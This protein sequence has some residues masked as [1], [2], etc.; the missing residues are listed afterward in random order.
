MLVRAGDVT[1][2]QRAEQ[3]H[4]GGDE[5]LTFRTRTSLP[6]Y[7]DYVNYYRDCTICSTSNQRDDMT[8]QV[9]QVTIMP[10]AMVITWWPELSFVGGSRGGGLSFSH[11]LFTIK[12]HWKRN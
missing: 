2:V 4:G 12:I 8:R 5:P 6:Q 7:N 3:G 11:C 1:R 10:T 9:T